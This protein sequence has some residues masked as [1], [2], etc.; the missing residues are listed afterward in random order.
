MM[1]LD[2]IRAALRDRRP[3]AVAAAFEAGIRGLDLPPGV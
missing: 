1:T 3:G 2:Q